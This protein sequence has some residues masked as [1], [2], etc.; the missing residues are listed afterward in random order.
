MV[1]GDDDANDCVLPDRVPAPMFFRMMVFIAM[2]LPDAFKATLFGIESF[3]PCT[4]AVTW[5]DAVGCFGSPL[6]ICSAW[7]NG[8]G[9]R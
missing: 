6:V 1:K 3:P 4:V 8:P 5:T 9:A 7:L 2:P